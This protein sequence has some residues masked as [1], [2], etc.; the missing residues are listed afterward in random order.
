MVSDLCFSLLALVGFVWLF[1]L[2]PVGWPSGCEA[3]GHTPATAIRPPR[4]RSRDPQPCGGLTHKPHGA[5]CAQALQAPLRTSPAA[6]P[7]RLTATRGRKRP[8]DPAHHG[9]PDPAWAYGGWLGLGHITSHGHPRSGP[10]RQ[11]YGR[12]CGGV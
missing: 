1:V 12:R 3:G 4:Q 9:C 2:L 8:V 10:G 6:P 5:A 7:P 11:L